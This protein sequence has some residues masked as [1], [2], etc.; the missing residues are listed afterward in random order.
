MP[1]GPPGRR[2]A[3]PVLGVLGG[4]LGSWSALTDTTYAL[5]LPA[6]ITL[7]AVLVALGAGSRRGQAPPGRARR[8]PRGPRCAAPC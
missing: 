6:K 1:S 7:V 5:L 3:P 4:Q 8:T 2:L